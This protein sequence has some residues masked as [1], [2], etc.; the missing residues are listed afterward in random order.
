ME[1]KAS[2]EQDSV[3]YSTSNRNNASSKGNSASSNGNS[4]SSIGN[5]ASSTEHNLAF[6]NVPDLEV[7]IETT[8][9]VFQKFSLYTPEM[10]AEI[11]QK[12]AEHKVIYL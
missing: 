2:D 5:S 1:A 8:Y 9:K 12:E 4:G 6:T 7:I 3:I 11:P 10:I